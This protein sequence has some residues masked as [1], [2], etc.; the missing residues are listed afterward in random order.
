MLLS[1][2]FRFPSVTLITDPVLFS[3]TASS[4]LWGTWE[5]TGPL[6]ASSLLNVILWKL[7]SKLRRNLELLAWAQ[8]P[9]SSSSKMS[10]GLQ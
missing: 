8:A 6:F 5:Q 10:C 4:H 1:E 2:C 7:L 3:V 9:N